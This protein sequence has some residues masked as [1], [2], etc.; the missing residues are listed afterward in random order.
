MLFRSVDV[1]LRRVDDDFCDPLELRNDSILGV[2]G[3]VEAARA[4]NVAIVNALGSGLLQSPAFK[5]FLPGLCRHVLGEKLLMPSVATW[6]CG[7]KSAE[8]YVLAHLDELTVKPAFRSQQ[9]MKSEVLSNDELRARIRFQPHLWVAQE[10]VALST[11]PSWD[12]SGLVAKRAV[13]REIGR[14]HV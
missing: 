5:S 10:K 14:A 9:Q 6:W 11:A 1:I 12:R 4:G 3:L 2:P 7:Q 13:V 8:N